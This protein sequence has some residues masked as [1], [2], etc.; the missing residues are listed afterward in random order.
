MAI[1]LQPELVGSYKGYSIVDYHGLFYGVPQSLGPVD[2]T[3]KKNRSRQ[4]F[5]AEE[6]RTELEK[7][8]R[9]T[10]SSP[11]EL[12]GTYKGYG[13]VD[14]NGLFYG[15]PQ[16]LGP[17]DLTKEKNRNHKEVLAEEDRTELEKRIRKVFLSGF[18]VST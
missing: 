1:L 7:R 14:Y 3:E 6:D 10:I 4:E 16:S 11:P 2:L 15:V 8:I 13:I 18:Q 5:L 12:V 17:V 9:K